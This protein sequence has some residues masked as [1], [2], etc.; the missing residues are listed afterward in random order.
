M[1]GKCSECGRIMEAL[2]NLCDRCAKRMQ[3]ESERRARVPTDVG[4]PGYDSAD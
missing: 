4:A 1:I 2:V 3:E